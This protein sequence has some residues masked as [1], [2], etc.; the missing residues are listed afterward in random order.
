MKKEGCSGNTFLIESN[1][2]RLWLVCS[3][4]HSKYDIDIDNQGV[5]FTS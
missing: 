4:C 5:Y 3:Q 1:E 2:D